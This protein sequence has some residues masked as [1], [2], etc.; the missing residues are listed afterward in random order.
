MNERSEL[1]HVLTI[2]HYIMRTIQEEK[3]AACEKFLKTLRKMYNMEKGECFADQQNLMHTEQ[4]ICNVSDML[5][6]LQ[7][8]SNKINTI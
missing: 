5:H 3:I 2:I 6:E 4:M 7:T 8:Q 1:I